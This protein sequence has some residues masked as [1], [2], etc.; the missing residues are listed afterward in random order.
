[1]DKKAAVGIG[2]AL[3]VVGLFIFIAQMTGWNIQWSTLWPLIPLAIGIMML[4][5]VDKDKGVIFPAIILIGI[6][7][8][9][10][11]TE[12]RILGPGIGVGDLW[13]FFV[14]I[15]GLGFV[16][17]WAVDSKNTGVLVPA[18]ICLITGTVF[19]AM[20]FSEDT[21]WLTYL[22]PIL[23][24]F[25]GLAIIAGSLLKKPDQTKPLPPQGKDETDGRA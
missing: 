1:M 23:I 8:L 19:L 16:G 20:R 10:L 21:N 25:I 15:P 6:G 13:P 22:L 14:I 9:F 5:R 18:A 3:I 11:V 7:A 24:V 12:S 4:F 17:L 2:F